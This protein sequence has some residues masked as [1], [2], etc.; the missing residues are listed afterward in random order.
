MSP[1]FSLD[2][3]DTFTAIQKLQAIINTFP[4]SE[5][6]EEAN[7]MILELQTKLEKKDFEISKQYYT[8]RDYKAAVKSLDNF[9]AS[10]PGTKFRENALFYKFNALYEIAINSIESKKIRTP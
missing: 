5:Y 2:Q 6:T 4:D 7:Q 1:R 8:I 3:E 9:I 10:F